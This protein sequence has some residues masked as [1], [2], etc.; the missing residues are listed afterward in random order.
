MHKLKS[1][2]VELLRQGSSPEDISL[3]IALGFTLGTIPVLGSTTLLCAFAALSL[4]LNIALIMLVNYFAYPI[5]LLIYIPLLLLGANWL[6]SSVTSLTLEGVYHM[7]RSD[8][9]GAIKRLF[10]ANLGGVLI[11]SCVA[12]PLGFLIYTSTQRI[13][14][15][16]QKTLPTE[17]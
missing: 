15:N 11:W 2:I 1:R 14:R 4:R 8:M 17:P 13:M 10:W 16:F 5:Q 6:D 3:T 9:W 12:T 7:L